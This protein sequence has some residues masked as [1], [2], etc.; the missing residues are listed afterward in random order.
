MTRRVLIFYCDGVLADTGHDGHAKVYLG[1][2]H[3]TFL[4]EPTSR[5]SLSPFLNPAPFW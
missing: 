4:T 3:K 5:Q 2:S 1:E